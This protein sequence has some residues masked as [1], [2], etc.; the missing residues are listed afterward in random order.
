MRF[1]ERAAVNLQPNRLTEELT[2]LRQRRRAGDRPDRFQP[3]RGGAVLSPGTVQRAMSAGDLGSYRPE[4]RGAERPRQAVVDAIGRYAPDTLLLTASTSEA[5]ALLLKLLCDP[6]DEV[7]VPRPSYPLFEHLVRFEGARAVPYPL[8]YAGCW[9]IDL[10]EVRAADHQPHPCGD[11]GQPQQPHGQLRHRRR[12]IVPGA[13]VRRPRR[14]DLRRGIPR[15]STQRPARTPSI[16]RS[17]P[18]WPLAWAVCPSWW[19]CPSS[20]C[21][22]SGSRATPRPARPP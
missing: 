13:A 15:V 18:T 11:R 19:A 4:A 10:A 6:G 17:M 8:R 9:M 7:L 3:H 20:S 21:P 2:R 5:Y 14:A 12:A 1:S 16:A 22:G